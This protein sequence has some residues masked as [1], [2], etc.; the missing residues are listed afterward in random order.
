[1]PTPTLHAYPY[2]YPYFY[3]FYYNYPVLNTYPPFFIIIQTFTA[4]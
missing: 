3:Y 4:R 2:Y 1:M